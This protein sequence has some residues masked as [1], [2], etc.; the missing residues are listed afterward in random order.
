MAIETA[1]GVEPTTEMM[2]TLPRAAYLS[3]GHFAREAERIFH[4]EW[5]AVGREEAIPTAGDY[6]HVEVADE[7]VLIVR[8]RSGELN[9]FYNVCRHRG[10][11]LVMEDPRPEPDGP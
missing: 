9:A 10:S 5:F 6:L 2:R 4:R 8:A 7:S 3:D 11:R 1:P